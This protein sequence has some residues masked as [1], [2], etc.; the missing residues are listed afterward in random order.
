MKKILPFII[1]ITLL[2]G[3]S[4]QP[5]QLSSA[6]FQY[7]KLYNQADF[8]SIIQ[9]NDSTIIFAWTEWCGAS[10]NMLKRYLI[11]FL[12]EKPDNIGIISI[13]C[14]NPS[15][16]TSFIEENECKHVVYLLSESW[17]GLDKWKFNKFFH[18]QFDNYH[19]VNYVPIVILCDKQ[20]QILN[21]DAAS[22][23]YLDVGSVIWQI[24]NS[25]K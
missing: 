23:Q 11:P 8:D 25:N 4:T 20:K 16:L 3:C 6:D 24:E 2:C 15:K 14:A 5:L 1:T 21:W 12:K 17:S 22:E 18:A 9:H 10:H 7:I 13:C 19:S